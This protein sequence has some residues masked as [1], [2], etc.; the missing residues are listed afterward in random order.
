[1]LEN[2][3]RVVSADQQRYNAYLTR[4]EAR[5]KSIENTKSRIDPSSRVLLRGIVI[6]NVEGDIMVECGLPVQVETD[7]SDKPSA[8]IG[9][10]VQV[11]GKLFINW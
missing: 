8:A 3:D 5:L 10:R 1:M 11:A 2:I 9:E 4:L 6:E 7:L